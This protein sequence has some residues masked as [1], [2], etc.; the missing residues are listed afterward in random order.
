M[1]NPAV[2]TKDPD[3]DMSWSLPNVTGAAP[4]RDGGCTMVCVVVCKD[5]SVEHLY[6]GTTVYPDNGTAAVGR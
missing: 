5:T 2:A 6:D 4:P 1:A 3:Y